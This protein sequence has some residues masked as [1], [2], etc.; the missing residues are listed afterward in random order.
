[1]VVARAEAAEA[2]RAAQ[3]GS[4]DPIIYTRDRK[5]IT[6]ATEPNIPHEA[7]IGSTTFGC[8]EVGTTR[9][10]SLS[11]KSTTHATPLTVTA[12][13]KRTLSSHRLMRRW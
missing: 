13:S 5:L 8:F 10:P 12:R 9:F 1:M 3:F 4:F 6:V 11:R 2:R 7:F